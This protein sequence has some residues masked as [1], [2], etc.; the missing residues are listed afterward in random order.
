MSECV[1]VSARE[2]ER[3][4]ERES[5]SLAG[6]NLRLKKYEQVKRVALTDIWPKRAWELKAAADVK[7]KKE[8]QLTPPIKIFKIKKSSRFLLVLLF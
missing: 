2:R 4:R 5:G 1:C 7:N 6:H 3:E 8:R